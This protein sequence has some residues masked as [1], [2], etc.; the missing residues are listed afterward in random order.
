[1][2]FVP[3]TIRSGKIEVEALRAEH[4]SERLDAVLTEPVD[5]ERLG[6][7]EAAEVD[8]VPRRRDE[9]VP[10]RVRELVQDDDRPLAAVHDEVLHVVVARC[11]GAE[12]APVLRVRVLDVLEAPRRPEPLY[13]HFFQ[14][15]KPSIPITM[16]TIATTVAMN[17]PA[18]S[19]PGKC[20]FMPKKPVM[21]VSGSMTTL[22]IVST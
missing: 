6:V 7:V 21:N 17:P 10:R 19:K 9:Q 13:S 18:L 22:K 16:I 14:R 2:R 1:M 5:L 4:G 20:T 11:G 8:A 12:E 15:K 3:E